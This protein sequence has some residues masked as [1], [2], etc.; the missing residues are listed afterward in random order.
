[1][2][3]CTL[4]IIVDCVVEKAFS[5]MF[6]GGYRL[7]QDIQVIQCLIVGLFYKGSLYANILF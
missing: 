1:M 2:D 3:T 6:C 7:I 4:M 5:F